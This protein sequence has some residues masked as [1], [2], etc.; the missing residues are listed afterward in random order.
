[1]LQLIFLRSLVS[2]TALNSIQTM[3]HKRFVTSTKWRVVSGLLVV[4]FALLLIVVLMAPTP[5][6]EGTVTSEEGRAVAGAIVRVQG[7]AGFAVTDSQGKFLLPV[8]SADSDLHLTAWAPGHYIAVAKAVPSEKVALE[9]HQHPTH[10]N[11]DYE[12]ISPLLDP[13]NA[14]MCSQC[15]AARSESL[16]GMLPVDEWKLDAHASAAV[17]PRFLSLYNG[18]DLNG[19]SGAR[20]RSALAGPEGSWR[21]VPPRFSERDRTLCCLPCT[22]ARPERVASGGSQPGRGSR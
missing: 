17:N 12:F 5:A 14:A 18:T 1:M 2:G 3:S 8:Y 19:V 4:A 21:R 7:D 6:V 22:R 20:F 11:P 16:A 15:H 9:I 10:D 13:D